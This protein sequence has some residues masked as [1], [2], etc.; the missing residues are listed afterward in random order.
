M[1]KREIVRELEDIIVSGEKDL[2]LEKVFDR[3]GEKT[4]NPLKET[5]EE[6]FDRL[7]ELIDDIR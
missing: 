5:L 2:T 6:V 3:Y 4:Q 7:D 1:N